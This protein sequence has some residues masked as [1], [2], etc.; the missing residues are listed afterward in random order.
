ML[1]DLRGNWECVP[2]RPSG[3]TSTHWLTSAVNDLDEG[4]AGLASQEA[5]LISLEEAAEKAALPS[6]IEVLLLLYINIH[7]L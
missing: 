4:I 1:R 7:N 6:T 5:G 2:F 3:F